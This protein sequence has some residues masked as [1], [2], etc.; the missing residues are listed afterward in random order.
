MEAEFKDMGGP[1]AIE[2]GALQRWIQSMWLRSICSEKRLLRRR[3]QEDSSRAQGGEQHVVEFFYGASDPYSHLAAQTLCKLKERHSLHFKFNL[4]SQ[5][6][7][8]NG[9]EP[10]MLRKLN[11]VDC[12]IVAQAYGLEFPDHDSTLDPSLV[13]LANSILSA[14]S[15]ENF[16]AIVSEVGQALWEDDGVRL[17]KLKTKFGGLDDDES[18]SCIERGNARREKLGHYSEA[19]FYYGGEWYWGIDRLHHL[20]ERLAGLLPG[21][22]PEIPI[23]FP[24]PKIEN[25]PLKDD[26]SLTLEFFPTLRSPYTAII[27]ERVVKLASDTGIALKV[28]PVLPM[29]MRGVPTT[30]NKGAYI[31]WDAAREARSAGVPFG[32]IYD[33]VGRPVRRC[34]SLYPWATQQG[35]GVDLLGSFLKAVMSEGINCDNDRGLRSVVERAGLNWS[36]A[37]KHIGDNEWEPL[38]ERN[39]RQLYSLGIWG[40]PSFRLLDNKGVQKSAWWGQDRLWIVSRQVQQLLSLRNNK[41]TK[42]H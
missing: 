18:L 35:K 3:K 27:F 34:Y 26:G 15:A 22:Q 36:D 29:V 42:L 28:L 38:L 14:Q 30:K 2:V 21:Q 8:D 23:C 25:G 5:P 1:S 19:M 7:G 13:N 4:V 39:R 37:R 12:R 20:E 33:P 10:E 11:R 17:E 9:P 40:T 41:N 31:F 6:S 24:R 32:K 16:I